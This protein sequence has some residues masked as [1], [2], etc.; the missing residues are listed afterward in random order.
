M[1]TIA[2]VTAKDL[3][4]HQP[5]HHPSPPSCWEE[6]E[7]SIDFSTLDAD[8]FPHKKPMYNDCSHADTLSTAGESSSWASFTCECHN[9]ECSCTSDNSTAANGD[10]DDDDS[11]SSLTLDDLK[12]FFVEDQVGIFN[13]TRDDIPPPKARTDYKGDSQNSFTLDDLALDFEEEEEEGEG[14]DSLGC[15]LAAPSSRRASQRKKRKSSLLVLQQQPKGIL[16]NGTNN[17]RRSSSLTMLM[18][19]DSSLFQLSGGLGSSDD[20]ESS[21]D[22]WGLMQQSFGAGD[23][24]LDCDW[25]AMP[26]KR[27]TFSS[28]VVHS[29]PVVVGDNPSVTEGVPLMLDWK[30][31]ETSTFDS[32]E[33]YEEEK[34]A[35][36][37]AA[38]TS[39]R[40]LEAEERMFRLLSAGA[41]L[42]DIQ[43]AELLVNKTRQEREDTRQSNLLLV[44]RT[45][46]WKAIKQ[47]ESEQEEGEPH[48][49]GPSSGRRKK[50]LL[51]SKNVLL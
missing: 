47:E 50:T 8:Q 43:K 2:L 14:N 42:Q 5:Q 17:T 4:S 31:E 32:L 39:V 45:N 20:E 15:L 35:Q 41:S 18:M 9:N 12:A 21:M 36:P 29:H 24:A 6:D 23:D 7:S 51:S 49:L 34:A 3:Y 28:V 27:V 33:D 11:E 26:E 16:K 30:A 13:P 48:L 25:L 19:E 10:N 22:G 37:S 46:F 44:H 40:K 1:N 38:N